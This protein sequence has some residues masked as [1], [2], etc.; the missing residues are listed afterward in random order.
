MADEPDDDKKKTAAKDSAEAAEKEEAAAAEKSEV[1]SP[2]PSKRKSLTPAPPTAKVDS[3]KASAAKVVSSREKTAPSDAV[4]DPATT[5]AEPAYEWPKAAWGKPLATLDRKWTKLEARLVWGVL[6]AEIFALVFTVLISGLATDP[7]NGAN[8]GIV[9]RAVL[10]ALLLGGVTYRVMRGKKNSEI[11]VTVAVV[12]GL[13]LGSRWANSGV[14]Y[15]GNIRNWLQNAS[16]L[17]LVG[18]VSQLAKRLTLWLALLGA[19]VAT[20]Q[21]KHINVDVVMR[22]L[23]PKARVPVAVL[24]WLFA[25][26][27]SFAGVIAFFDE[28]AIADYQAT[29]Q[30]PCVSDPLKS[31]Q[32]T[33]GERMAQMGVVIR[34]DLFLLGRQASLD[35][36]S[37]PKILSGQRY[38]DFFTAEE[39]NEWMRGGGWE[40]YYPKA[41]VDSLQM[42]EGANLKR[43][44][45]I[46]VPGAVEKP[47][48]LL[49]RE[50]DLIVPFGLFMIGLRFVLRALLALS[51]WIKVDPNSAHQDDHE[52][53]DDPTE[54][55]KSA[56][57]AAKED[58]DAKSAGGAA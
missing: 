18:G 3:K 40:T 14:A 52:D 20:A 48:E 6:A 32:T 15:F 17:L 46:I 29:D 11:V 19:S 31:C 2:W 58:S 26:I 36:H 53:E 38:D 23:G 42:P 21:G 43:S 55:K 45:A 1:A 44:P 10:T 4:S 27:V 28:L 41:D 5:S 12:I 34:R 9:L 22:F 16:I 33:E 56:K 37:L 13:Y 50:L 51:G 7:G 25:G 39:W 8:S 57:Q 49:I 47:E 54:A 35:V 30:K 24:G